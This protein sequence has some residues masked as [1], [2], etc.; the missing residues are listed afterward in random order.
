MK[1]NYREVRKRSSAAVLSYRLLMLLRHEHG[2]YKR[3]VRSHGLSKQGENKLLTKD[4][5]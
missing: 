2:L 5:G 1:N 4:K 3:A